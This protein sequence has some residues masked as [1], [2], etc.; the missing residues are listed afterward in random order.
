ML[1]NF[2]LKSICRLRLSVWVNQYSLHWNYII[3]LSCGWNQHHLHQTEFQQLSGPQQRILSWFSLILGR[4][5]ILDHGF[6]APW[7][8]WSLYH[9]HI[10]SS[11]NFLYRYSSFSIKT[12]PFSSIIS[13]EHPDLV[14]HCNGHYILNFLDFFLSF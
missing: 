2:S 8:S 6:I 12:N 13:L 11:N 4:L 7:N 1:P 9:H 5:H 3:W 14:D 10:F